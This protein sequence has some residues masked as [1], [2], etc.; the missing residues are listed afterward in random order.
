MT[1]CDYTTEIVGEKMQMRGG[2]GD[3]DK[4]GESYGGYIDDTD[5]FDPEK[6]PF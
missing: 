1:V 5:A 3:K 6:Y 2:K 4:D